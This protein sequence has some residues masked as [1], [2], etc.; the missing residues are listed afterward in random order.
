MHYLKK[1]YFIFIYSQT[2]VNALI[3]KTLPTAFG[4]PDDRSNEQSKIKI[5]AA[6]TRTY[7]RMRR[8]GYCS[9]MTFPQ[10]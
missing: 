4:A 10:I 9:V 3:L 1:E 8:S 7:E 6:R 5:W 2:T